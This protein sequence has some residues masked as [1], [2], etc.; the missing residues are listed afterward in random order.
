MITRFFEPKDFDKNS[1]K[2]V[3]LLDKI[4][5]DRSAIRPNQPPGVAT[6][7]NETAYV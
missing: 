5:S 4:R 7:K 3:A 6:C 2:C 1:C